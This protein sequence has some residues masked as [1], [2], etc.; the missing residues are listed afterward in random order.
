MNSSCANAALR[1]VLPL[2]GPQVPL[3][4]LAEPYGRPAVEP[5]H[6]VVVFFLEVLVYAYLRLGLQVL[7]HSS[8]CLIPSS[9]SGK[10]RTAEMS[11]CFALNT[12]NLIFVAPL[13]QRTAIE[14]LDIGPTG[15]H[16]WSRLAIILTPQ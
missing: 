8:H 5:L 7:P 3:L 6:V 4:G 9:G 13:A 1:F 16:G 11:H 2:H 10:R 12:W 15:P 14:V